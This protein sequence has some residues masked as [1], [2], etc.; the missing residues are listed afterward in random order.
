MALCGLGVTSLQ[1]SDPVHD[2]QIPAGAG[3]R[4]GTQ[5]GLEKVSMGRTARWEKVESRWKGLAGARATLPEQK[6]PASLSPG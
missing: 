2:K 5:G 6:L 4:A 1:T 3:R